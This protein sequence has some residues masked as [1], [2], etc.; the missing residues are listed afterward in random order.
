MAKVIVTWDNG[1]GW[2]SGAVSMDV[3]HLSQL[4]YLFYTATKGMGFGYIEN[5]GIVVD[6]DEREYWAQQYD[7]EPVFGVPF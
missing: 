5:L 4:S 6:E 2:D 1:E 3:E 7:G